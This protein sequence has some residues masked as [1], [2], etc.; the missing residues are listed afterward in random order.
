MIRITLLCSLGMSTSILVEKMKEDANSLGLEI[1][2]D[3]LP[4]DR[5]GERI[6][7]TDI[8][9]LGPQIRYLLSKFQNDYGDT[10]PV[11]ATINM[12]DYALQNTKKILDEALVQ[13]N[14]NKKQ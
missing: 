9:L 2:I 14:K 6:K 8:L 11:I 13:Y 5:V 4:F 3:A 12:P 1:D 10:I 7:T